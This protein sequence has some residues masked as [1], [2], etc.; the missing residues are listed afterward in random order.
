LCCFGS[1][2]LWIRHLRM[3]QVD[4][5]ALLNSHRD[6][7]LNTCLYVCRFFARVMFVGSHRPIVDIAFDS[8]GV[9][10]DNKSDSGIPMSRKR[11]FFNF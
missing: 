4:R 2:W 10:I 9:W 3:I 6:R 7:W 1:F 11:I 8:S 5:F